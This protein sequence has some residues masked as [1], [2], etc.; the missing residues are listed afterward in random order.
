MFP[1]A[2][3]G[4]ATNGGFLCL[5]PLISR[6]CSEV[7]TPLAVAVREEYSPWRSS[8]GPHP[9]CR[10]DHSGWTW[11]RK[12]TRWSSHRCRLNHRTRVLPKPPP[13]GTSWQRRYRCHC[14]GHGDHWEGARRQWVVLVGSGVHRWSSWAVR[15]IC[16]LAAVDMPRGWLDARTVE[17]RRRAGDGRCTSPT[18]LA[19]A[20][21]WYAVHRPTYRHAPPFRRIPR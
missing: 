8:M 20:L 13:F 14:G 4:Q 12:P 7:A 6:T 1:T 17:R 19:R 2:A 5:E 3:A 21:R 10:D 11:L 16:L 15:G 18:E 9:G